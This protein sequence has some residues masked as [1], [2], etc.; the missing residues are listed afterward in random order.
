MGKEV[1]A[2]FGLCG[3]FYREGDTGSSDSYSACST[4]DIKA[5]VL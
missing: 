1:L 2:L 5:S 3:V 4:Y